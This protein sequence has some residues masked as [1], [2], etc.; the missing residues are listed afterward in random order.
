MGKAKL[1]NAEEAA[2]LLEADAELGINQATKDGKL[3]RRLSPSLRKQLEK[4]AAGVAPGGSNFANNFRALAK[5]V[6]VSYVTLYKKRNKYPKDHP[7][8]FPKPRDNNKWNILEVKQWMERDKGN[9]APKV[10]EEL[11]PKLA[12]EIARGNVKLQR[13]QFQLGIQTREYIKREEVNAH[14][15]T[16]NA[17]VAREF[18]KAFVH[19]LPPLCEGLTAAEIQL[20]N[21]E[22]LK[23]ILTHLP[24]HLS[25][26]IPSE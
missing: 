5:A 19:E 20:M 23:E 6:G 21:E 8:A 2:A 24:R 14:I 15:D 18:V 17:I 26:E 1:P 4:V 16:A 12:I 9:S 3:T 13:E 7:S 11:N 22:R 25:A 10:G